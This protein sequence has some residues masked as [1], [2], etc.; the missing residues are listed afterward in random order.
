[1]IYDMIYN[2]C[3]FYSFDPKVIGSLV[4]SSVPKPAEHLV[5]FEPG[6]LRLVLQR[7]NPP[8]QSP[9]FTGKMS[10]LCH[11]QREIRAASV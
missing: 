5:G 4:T 9:S 11:V 3:I 2:P 8:G 10:S 6:N 7:L 1:M